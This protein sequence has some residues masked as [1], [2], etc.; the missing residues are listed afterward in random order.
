MGFCG[1]SHLL[2]TT[3]EF[4]SIGSACQ[5]P[6]QSYLTRR[7]VFPMSWSLVQLWAHGHTHTGYQVWVCYRLA[8]DQLIVYYPGRVQD[9]TCKWH[10]TCRRQHEG[11][12]G[13]IHILWDYAGAERVLYMYHSP[14]DTIQTLNCFGTSNRR[15]LERRRNCLFFSAH[16]GILCIILPSVLWQDEDGDC[17]K[18]L[19]RLYGL[20]CVLV[21]TAPANDVNTFWMLGSTTI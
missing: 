7:R 1:A 13:L 2:P 6:V 9:S 14:V 5:S 20:C 4:G 18:L 15:S 3:F 19:G 21:F 12:R 17:Y 10:K 11:L 8:R 16:L